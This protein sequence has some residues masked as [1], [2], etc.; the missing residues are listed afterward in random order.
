M[1]TRALL[2]IRPE[3]GNARTLA[4]AR[5]L[6][7]VARG[8]PLFVV[9]L[10]AWEPPDPA[11]FDAALLGS[12]NALRH[13]GAA[14]ARYTALPIYAVGATTAA[15][16]RTAG[17]TVAACGEGGLQALLPHLAADGRK[18]VLR[19]SGEAHVPLD[20]PPGMTIETAIVYA[21]RALA[22][23]ASAV[24]PKTL[25]GLGCVVA[26]HSGEAARHFAAECD[27]LGLDRAGIALCCLAPRVAE[28]AGAGW[29][30]TRV[31]PTS[32]RLGP[33][34]SGEA[35]LLA[36]ARDMCQNALLPNH[37]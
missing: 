31:A 15:A 7:L 37:R 9:E 16:A 20:P 10:R 4:A 5:T 26:L 33:K 21:A 3:P 12:A 11:R 23:P 34:H 6:G 18:R 19:L 30:E 32:K 27:R 8:I 24:S 36:L 17:F 22:L 13:G 35:A 2:V 14:L 1:S 29:A 25:E 28:A